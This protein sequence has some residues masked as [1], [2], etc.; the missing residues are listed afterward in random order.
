MDEMLVSSDASYYLPADHYQIKNLIS[1]AHALATVEEEPVTYRGLEIA[2]KSNER[3]S[4]EFRR[5]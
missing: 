3:L 5:A 1:I 4:E 2:A